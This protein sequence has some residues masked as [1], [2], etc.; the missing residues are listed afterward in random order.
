MMNEDQLREYIEL[1]RQLIAHLL[2]RIQGHT[3]EGLALMQRIQDFEDNLPCN[4]EDTS[5]GQ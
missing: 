5:N 1:Q 3:M 2:K 4:Q